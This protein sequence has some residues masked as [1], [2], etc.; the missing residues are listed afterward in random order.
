[1]YDFVSGPFNF[2]LHDGSTFLV[3]T[4]KTARKNHQ[5]M[6]Y[7]ESK[8]NIVNKQFI[9]WRRTVSSPVKQ[10]ITIT[11]LNLISAS[12][13]VFVYSIYNF[14]IPTYG[15]GV[16]HTGCSLTLKSHECQRKTCNLKTPQEGIRDKT[17]GFI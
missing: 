12:P 13:I 7:K 16:Q 4:A 11:D 17:V 1:M 14:T 8:L 6:L 10:G 15:L 3:S 9:L 5:R 2:L